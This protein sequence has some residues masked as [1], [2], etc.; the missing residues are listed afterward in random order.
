MICRTQHS[1]CSALCALVLL[2]S[3]VSVLAVE[4]EYNQKPNFSSQQITAE[5]GDLKVT[6]QPLKTEY[7]IGEKIQFKFIPNKSVYLYLFS[8]DQENNTGRVLLPNPLQTDN[9]YPKPNRFHLVPHTKFNLIADKEGVELFLMVAS[10]QELELDT[11]NLKVDGNIWGGTADEVQAKAL[12]IRRKSQT[13]SLDLKVLVVPQSNPNPAPAPQP[14]MPVAN[15]DE[16]IAGV[17]IATSRQ[18]YRVG[19]NIKIVYG[20]DQKGMV[21]LYLVEPDDKRRIFH[22]QEVDGSSIYTLMAI[23]TE[24]IG[25]HQLIVEYRNSAKTQQSKGLEMLKSTSQAVYHFEISQ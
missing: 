17:F 7:R 6:F 1:L 20:A 21:K 11:K 18:Q 4:I 3:A 2:T 10:T 22:E 24:P 14:Q 16:N 12:S 23:A 13:V 5:Q 19:E 8:I 9:S 15:T 25:K